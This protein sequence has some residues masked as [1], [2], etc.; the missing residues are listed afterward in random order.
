[1]SFGLAC[2]MAHLDDCIDFD[3]LAVLVFCRS[4]L[5]SMLWLCHNAWSKLVVRCTD[6]LYE[7]IHSDS[8]LFPDSRNYTGITVFYFWADCYLPKHYFYFDLKRAVHIHNLY[9]ILPNLD[10][11]ACLGLVLILFPSDFN[12][13]FFMTKFFKFFKLFTL[14]KSFIYI[15]FSTFALFLYLRSP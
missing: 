1:M 12:L 10:K 15:Q 9:L 11:L 4:L 7:N 6:A 8:Q 14:F 5:N 2:L 3:E 13:L